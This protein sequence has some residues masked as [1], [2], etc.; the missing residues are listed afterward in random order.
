[1]QKQFEK[2][3]DIPSNADV[4]VMASYITP[5][6]MLVTEIPLS[7]NHHL[8]QSTPT[9]HLSVN[10]TPNDQRRLSFSLNKF[11]TLNDQGLSSTSNNLSS[12]PPPGQQVRRT[13]VTKTTTTTTSTGGT[14]LPPEATELLRTADSTSPGT[15]TYSTRVAE[16]RPSNTNNHQIVINEPPPAPVTTTTTLTNAGTSSKSHCCLP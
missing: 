14:G 2:A 5:N 10:N 15:H 11:N 4:E 16:R 7:S 9:N 13:S 12:L 1:M 6:H 8:Q 3:F